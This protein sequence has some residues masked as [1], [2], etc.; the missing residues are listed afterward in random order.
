M[1]RTT[2]TDETE[3]ISGC[4][5]KS[6]SYANVQTSVENNN[7]NRSREL[8]NKILNIVSIMNRPYS[9]FR[10]LN[11]HNKIVIGGQ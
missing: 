3:S 10:S 11:E 7:L 1:P 4:E 8:K 2:S 9:S 5:I 6:S